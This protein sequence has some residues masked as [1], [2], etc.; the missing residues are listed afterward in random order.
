[1]FSG[2]DSNYSARKWLFIDYLGSVKK[3]NVAMV[4]LGFS[5]ILQ[6]SILFTRLDIFS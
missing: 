5:L 1:M 6:L 3:M 2:Q 4:T